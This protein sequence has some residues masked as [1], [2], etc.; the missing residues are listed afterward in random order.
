MIPKL[1]RL[2]PAL[3]EV[4]GEVQLLVERAIG[5]RPSARAAGRIVADVW[6]ENNLVELVHVFRK[7]GKKKLRRI[8]VGLG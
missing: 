8:D 3:E 2:D 1:A 6:R 7:S 4:I 5:V